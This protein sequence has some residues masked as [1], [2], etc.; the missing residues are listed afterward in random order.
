MSARRSLACRNLMR[1]PTALQ[2]GEKRIRTDTLGHRSPRKNY[3]RRDAAKPSRFYNAIYH[4]VVWAKSR[5]L[6]RFLEIDPLSWGFMV[7]PS[8]RVCNCGSGPNRNTALVGD[9]WQPAHVRV[10]PHLPQHEVSHVSSRDVHPAAGEPLRGDTIL[11]CPR[12]IGQDH[13]ANQRPVEVVSLNLLERHFAV[14]KQVAY[15]PPCERHHHRP[16]RI[17]CRLAENAE[18]RPGGRPRTGTS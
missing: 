14:A 3:P 7:G 9:R 1:A 18:V 5:G 2:G 12:L 16:A 6:L 10:A 13:G 17:R 8:G 4:G 11:P 15:P